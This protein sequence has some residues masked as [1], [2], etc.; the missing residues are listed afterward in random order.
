MP[1]DAIDKSL[2]DEALASLTA[3]RAALAVPRIVDD[4]LGE[5]EQSR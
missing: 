3:D 2:P 4:D 5:E 1:D